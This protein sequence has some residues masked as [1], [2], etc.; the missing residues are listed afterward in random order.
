[1]IFDSLL[2]DYTALHTEVF[3]GECKPAL[4]DETSWV[5]IF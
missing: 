1:M 2:H 3:Q 5:K 4:F